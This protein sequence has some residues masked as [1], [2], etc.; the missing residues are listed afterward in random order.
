[1]RSKI[2]ETARAPRG[3]VAGGVGLWM[4]PR[5]T[6]SQT[7]PK[8]G[9]FLNKGETWGSRP[10][11]RHMAFGSLVPQPLPPGFP[12]RPRPEAVLKNF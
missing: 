2:R 11:Q 7:H 10:E 5:E 1:M 8:D 9:G 4:G 12:G 6:V 3:R